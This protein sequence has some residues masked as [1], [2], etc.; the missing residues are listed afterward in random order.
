MEPML[1]ETS[2]DEGST[3]HLG[4]GRRPRDACD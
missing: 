2:K 4:K 1:I 3:D